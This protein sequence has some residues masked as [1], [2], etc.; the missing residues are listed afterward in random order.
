MSHIQPSNRHALRC[1][2]VTSLPGSPT[3]GPRS[4]GDLSLDI[5]PGQEQQLLGGDMFDDG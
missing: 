4:A 2:L 3:H 1:T 5:V